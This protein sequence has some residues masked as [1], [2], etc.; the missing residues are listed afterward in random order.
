MRDFGTKYKDYL[1][2]GGITFFI[3]IVIFLLKGIYP[4]GTNSLIYGDM[5]D[6]LT[7]SYYYLYD[8]IYNGQSFLI[9]FTSSGGINFFGILTSFLLNPFSLLILFVERNKIYLFV[10][11]IVV[12][13]LV[14]CNLTCCYMLK[15]LFKNMNSYLSVFLALLYG[16]SIYG[17]AYYQMSSWIDAMYIL[18]LIIVGL[19]ILFDFDKPFMYIVTLTLSLYF[20][21]YLSLI[22]IICLFLVSI[23]YIH[24]YVDKEKRSKKIL[25]LLLS[26]LLCIGCSFVVIL[27]TV[28]QFLSGTQISYSLE[29]I[30]N[31][32]WGLLTDKVSLFLFGPLIWVGLVLLLKNY[33]KHKEFLTFY[34]PAMILLC[35]PIIIEPVN[36]LL[37]LTISNCFPHSFGFITIIFL[38]IGV[39][40]Y[41]DSLETN[42][43]KIG[44]IKKTVSI[45]LSFGSI[46]T[47]IYI[48]ISKYDS[49]QEVI[50]SLT[51]SKD[52][53]L[54][55]FLVL[56]FLV[57]FIASIIIF[58][59]N[60]GFNKLSF[61]LLAL[62]AFTHIFATT[63]IYA[64]IDSIQKDIKTVYNGLQEMEYENEDNNYYRYKNDT[65]SIIM[66]SSNV[67]RFNSLDG[68]NSFIDKNNQEV[69]RKLGYSAGTTKTYS[70][71]GTL[72]TDLLLANKY[73][74]NNGKEP[75]NYSLKNQYNNYYLYEYN[76]DINFGYLINEN[77]DINKYEDSF[78]IQNAIYKSVTGSDKDLFEIIDEIK[79]FNINVDDN[80]YKVLSEQNYVKFNIKVKD[81]KELYLELDHFKDKDISK[82][83]DIYVNGEL[84]VQDYPNDQINGVVDLGTFKNEKVQATILFKKDCRLEKI[85]IGVL[86]LSMIN[87]FVNDSRLYYDLSY[88]K[89]KINIVID[90]NKDNL[91]F[92]PIT[93]NKGYKAYNNGEKIQ[94][95]KVYNNYIGVRLK[96]GVN[97]I[98]IE[99]MP[100]YLIQSL[101]V[102]IIFIILTIIL[103]TNLYNKLI[104]NKALQKISK[105]TYLTIYSLLVLGI[106]LL[107]MISFLISFFTHIKI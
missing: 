95:E 81:E 105:Y 16:F 55:S 33:K 85:K 51:F 28:Q 91:L 94:I 52:D 87:N 62:I 38:I 92:L 11:I 39:A 12:L 14:L 25:Q 36:K 49:L 1:L 75:Y 42:K 48:T 72:F 43:N 37:H 19:K 82:Y 67:T 53:V 102:T 47:I 15:K 74:L 68:Y 40:Y 83:F 59:L 41:F 97:R 78:Q 17:L 10:S 27:P 90:D 23:F 99:F 60:K 45:L 3:F 73:I 63:Y 100:P 34:I 103:N 9:N 70:N 2:A 76:D 58:I 98:T 18:P 104:D 66:N 22:V 30:L 96:D 64:G 7:S 29:E 5:Y 24:T 106:Y 57:S 20:S 8:C 93:Y 101:I 65:Q 44:V 56:M 35:L 86:D 4:F 107:P 21:F 69:L 13:K 50:N 61:N 71:G 84:I 26:N 6:K 31:S 89:N 77:I 32:K 79:T 46:V 88:Q 80:N 54:F